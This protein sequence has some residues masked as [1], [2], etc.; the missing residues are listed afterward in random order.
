MRREPTGGLGGR[1]RDREFE[2]GAVAVELSA[3]AGQTAF[4]CV[5]LLVC[6]S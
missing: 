5:R 3:I 2:T 4:S 1:M 6:V